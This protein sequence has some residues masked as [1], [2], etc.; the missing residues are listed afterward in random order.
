M[1]YQ[2]ILVLGGTGFV[3]RCLVDALVAQGRRVC[4][5]T[6][7]RAHGRDLLVLPTVD[8]VEADIHD[9]AVLRSLLSGRDAVINLV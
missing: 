3:G 8:V 5:P 9:G 7:R 2:N 6:R 1:A 4:V